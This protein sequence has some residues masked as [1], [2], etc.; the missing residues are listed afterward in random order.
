MFMWI[1]RKAFRNVSGTCSS[2]TSSNHTSRASG[3]AGG[4]ADAAAPAEV[5]TVAPGPAGGPTR[6]RRED[7]AWDTPA[8]PLLDSAGGAEAGAGAGGDGCGAKEAGRDRGSGKLR[9]PTSASGAT[10]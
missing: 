9:S 2:V 5:A 10:P 4:G 7:A 8:L 6:R 3:A 1:R